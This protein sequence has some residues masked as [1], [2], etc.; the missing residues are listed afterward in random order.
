MAEM[1]SG[2]SKYYGL[3]YICSGNFF[4]GCSTE[5]EYYKRPD[6]EQKVW[7]CE[8][9]QRFDFCPSCM[10]AYGKGHAHIMKEKSLSDLKLKNPSLYKDGWFC[11][12]NDFEQC[13]RGEISNGQRVIYEPLVKSWHCHDCEF[14]F[15]KVCIEKY[16]CAPPL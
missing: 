13:T 6:T 15:C 2:T 3:G 14:D 8:E 10:S 9:C 4:S 16:K 5:A 1:A 11:K 12:G 7:H